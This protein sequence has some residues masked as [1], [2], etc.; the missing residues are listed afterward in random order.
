MI[1]FKWNGEQI[2]MYSKSTST[3]KQAKSKQTCPKVFL[4]QEV[5]GFL[6]LYYLH[7]K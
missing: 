1:S 3:I 6:K 7:Q 2:T 5:A 4:Q